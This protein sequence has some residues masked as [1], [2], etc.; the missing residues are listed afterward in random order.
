MSKYIIRLDDAADRMDCQK[1]SQMERLLDKY[2]IKPL[3]GVIPNCKDKMMD[4]YDVDP[5]FWNKVHQWEDK[6]WTIALHGY[7]H[8]YC[9]DDG[10]INP[11]N[12][13]SEFAGLSLENQK[14][15]IK[16]G[17]EIFR[18]HGLEPKVFFAPS[19]TFDLNTLEALKQES[20]ISII[21]DTIA[22]KPYSQYG[23]T[24]VPQQS[25]RVRKLPFNVVT[26]CYHPNMMEEKEFIYL[27]RFFEKYKELFSNFPIYKETKRK[28][29]FDLIL[30]KL[31]FAKRTK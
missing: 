27:E 9:T 30:N 5:D 14:H 1:W 2:D 10:G 4:I 21:S 13:R 28:T 12:K 29:L 18:N 22:N 3:V 24:F 8:V 6:G 23:L 16:N 17:V 20:N 25:G 19:H 26:F 15:K 11:V 31:Y 7:E